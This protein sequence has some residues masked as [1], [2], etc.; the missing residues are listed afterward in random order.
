MSFVGLKIV[1]W[2]S[3][4]II[5]Y[6][7]LG[8]PFFLWVISLFFSSPVKAKR[9]IPYISFVVVAYNEENY[10]EDKI[11]NILELDY[12]EDM[13]EVIIG[14]DCSTDLTHAIVLKFKSKNVELII[15]SERMGKVNVLK[16]IIPQVQGEIVVFSDARQLFKKDALMNLVANFA[17]EQVGC[18]SGELILTDR[19]K[20]A[21][22]SGM[23]FYWNYEKFLREK[24]SNIGSM[25][26]ATGAIYAIRRKLFVSPPDDTILD[27]MFIP[28]KIIEQ[29]FRAI[30]TKKALAFDKASGSS[31]VEFR[32]KVRTLAGNFQVF[33]QCA[34]LFNPF[35]SKIWWQF[36][37]H[38]F[39][40]AFAFVFL[41]LI[42]C[43]NFFLRSEEIYNIIFVGQLIFY[44]LGIFGWGLDKMHKKIKL[45]TLSYVFC[46]LN[47][48]AM[49]GFIVFVFGKQKVVWK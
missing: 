35:K 7:Y 36:F 14:S 48:A 44:V 43:A 22:G 1:F 32:R 20:S 11:N 30:F 46:L 42:F 10:I 31:S 8:Y 41:L 12:P 33:V 47:I 4:L 3:L 40:R 17:D 15:A 45:F 5:F 13:I 28:L 21:V 16:K 34:N 19:G 39:L 29:G 6:T 9:I 23:G 26:G 18:V 49:I 2:V 38:K 27:D 24:E 25:L 37:S